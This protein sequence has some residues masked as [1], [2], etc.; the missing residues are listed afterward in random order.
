MAI[1]RTCPV[2]SRTQAEPFTVEYF[3][4]SIMHFNRRGITVTVK[5]ILEMDFNTAVERL[6]GC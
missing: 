1:H 5:V 3:R 4:G 2:V 6:A